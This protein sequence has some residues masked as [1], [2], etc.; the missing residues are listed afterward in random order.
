VADEELRLG[1][2]VVVVVVLEAEE[3]EVPVLPVVSVFESSDVVV[4]VRPAPLLATDVDD[5]DVGSAEALALA[6]GTSWATTAPMITV[7]P[8]V[9]R[10]APRVSARRRE[11]ALSL[12]VGVVG[13]NLSGM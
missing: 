10:I 2:D 13:W 5:E 6:P 3:E 12:S 7:V 11:R 1:A 9:A 8:V 4:E